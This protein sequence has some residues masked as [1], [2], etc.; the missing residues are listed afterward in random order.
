M[1]RPA[2]FSSN[3]RRTY[4]VINGSSA[5]IWLAM[6]LAPRSRLTR[7]LVKRATLLFVG[8]GLGYDVLLAS[9]I[10]R[11]GDIIDFR[12][13]DAVRDAL[14]EPAFFLAGWT[15]YIAFDLFVGRWI[16]EDS[17]A[18]GRR[19]R[20]ALILTWLAGPA[21]LSLYLAQIGPGRRNV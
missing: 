20:L 5:P 7:W 17:L 8:L 16:W 15:H 2:R 12:D 4:A 10:A 19:A 3:H 18:R 21:G 14:S 9:G 6:I 1:A 13:P 11:S